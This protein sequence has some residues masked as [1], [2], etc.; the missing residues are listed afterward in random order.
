LQLKRFIVP[1]LAATLLLLSD[2]VYADFESEVIE[3]VNAERAAAGIPPLGYNAELTAAARLHARDMADSNY[4]S[5]DSLDGTR[6]FERI[7]EAGYDYAACG[8][9]IAAGYANPHEVVDA[10]MDSDGHRENIL[11]PDFCEIGVGYAYVAESTYKHYWTQ[12]F[13]RKSG[14][15]QCP[16]TIVPPPGSRGSASSGDDGSGGCFIDTN[17]IHSK[18]VLRRLTRWMT[19]CAGFLLN[20]RKDL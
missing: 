13:G 12:D 14:V 16:D 4:F 7:L 11:D 2:A 3:R 17:R 5:H 1:I 18:E 15:T 8:E 9:N 6:F 19:R 20:F 10:W